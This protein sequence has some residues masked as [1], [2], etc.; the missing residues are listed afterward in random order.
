MQALQR[1]CW[2]LACVLARATTPAEVTVQLVRGQPTRGPSQAC[3]PQVVGSW[4]NQL[5]FFLCSLACLL[6][7]SLPHRLCVKLLVCDP[8][9]VGVVGWQRRTLPLPEPEDHPLQDLIRRCWLDP[10]ERPSFVEIG[11]HLMKLAQPPM[12][13]RPVA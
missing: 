9:V 10:G 13:G 6:V 12:T 5:G 2:G 11:N 8:Q 7:I 4:S 3:D 1:L